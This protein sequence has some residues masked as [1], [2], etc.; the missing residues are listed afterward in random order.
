MNG[1]FASDASF[2][3]DPLVAQSSLAS[4]PM[5]TPS[6]LTTEPSIFGSAPNQSVQSETVNTPAALKKDLESGIE[7]E[8]LDGTLMVHQ[9]VA[10]RL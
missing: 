9:C 6:T 7:N 5:P 4:S 3:N 10:G 8:Q 1:L 2:D